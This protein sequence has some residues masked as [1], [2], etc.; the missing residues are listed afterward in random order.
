MDYDLKF[1]ADVQM[2]VDNVREHILDNIDFNLRCGRK[3]EDLRSKTVLRETIDSELTSRISSE[4][5]TLVHQHPLWTDWGKDFEGISPVLFGRVVGMIRFSPP[6]KNVTSNDTGRERWAYSA[7][8]LVNYCGFGNG[9]NYNST[10]FNCMS[11]L[12]NDLLE[13]NNAYSTSFGLLLDAKENNMLANLQA[14]VDSSLTELNDIQFE[15]V[16][17][18]VFRTVAVQFIR[19]MY[20]VAQRLYGNNS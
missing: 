7:D 10:M 4:I 20:E 17:R 5:R 12:I 13:H 11:D 3:E 1:L 9:R 6:K 19:D 2:K 8:S 15:R 16:Y 18:D 14:N